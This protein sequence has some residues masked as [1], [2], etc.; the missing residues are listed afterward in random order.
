MKG[1]WKVGYYV[2]RYFIIGNVSP[3]VIVENM[4]KL[5][6]LPSSHNV[7]IIILAL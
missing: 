2:A 7:E 3:G 6:R 5:M 1:V 4:F